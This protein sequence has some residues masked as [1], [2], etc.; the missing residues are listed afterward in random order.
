M[1]HVDRP[2]LAMD[3]EPVQRRIGGHP[4]GDVQH[5]LVLDDEVHRG[6]EPL[7]DPIAAAVQLVRGVLVAGG[8]DEAAAALADG[9][10]QRRRAEAVGKPDY[11]EPDDDRVQ[12]LLGQFE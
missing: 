2:V 5:V 11:A 3:I 6:A 7:A 10:R 9:A 8:V 1:A 4:A 12:Y